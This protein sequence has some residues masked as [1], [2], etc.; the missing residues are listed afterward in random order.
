MIPIPSLIMPVR[1]SFIFDML[2]QEAHRPPFQ[3]PVPV[4]TSGSPTLLEQCLLLA[5]ARIV[6]PNAK[7][8]IFEFGTF[9]GATTFTLALNFPDATIDTLDLDPSQSNGLLEHLPAVQRWKGHSLTFDLD[10]HKA[11]IGSAKSLIFIDGGHDYRTA[12]SDT[13]NALEML[14]TDAPAA[15]VWHDY[16]Q[17]AWPGVTKAVDEFAQDHHTYSIEETNLAVSFQGEGA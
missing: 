1:P 15:I 9:R 8:G 12:Q 10:P 11:G 13:R 7:H 6:K 16:N 17:A 5:V 14:R 4:R 2:N 3:L